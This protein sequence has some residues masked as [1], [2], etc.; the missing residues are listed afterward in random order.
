MEFWIILGIVFLL[1]ILGA[2]SKGGKSGGG[3]DFDFDD[4]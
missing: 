1:C 3:I 4:D 2:F